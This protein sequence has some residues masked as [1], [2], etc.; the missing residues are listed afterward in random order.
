MKRLCFVLIL[1]SIVGMGFA[2]MSF[3]VTAQQYY[4]KDAGGL[5]PGGSTVWDDFVDGE[6]VYWGGMFEYLFKNVG[7]GVTFN[8]RYYEEETNRDLD[9][10]NYDL[11]GFIAY[12]I[13]GTRSVIDPFAQAGIGVWKYDYVSTAAAKSALPGYTGDSLAGSM[14]LDIGLGCAVNIKF[15]S[16]FA[17]TMWNFQSD[18]P[19]AGSYDETTETHTEVPM[20]DVLPFKW[21]FGARVIL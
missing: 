9:T 13:L 16:I 8:A 18:K 7:L 11:N 19:L 6:G 17:K 5:L 14:Y 4:T 15:A 2:D 12:H 10:W 3:G 1:V 21:V 20:L